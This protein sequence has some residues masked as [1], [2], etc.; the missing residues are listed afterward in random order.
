VD[1]ISLPH[2]FSRGT[3][4]SSADLALNDSLMLCSTYLDC[5]KSDRFGSSC[6]TAHVWRTESAHRSCMESGVYLPKSRN[7]RYHYLKPER[8]VL[9]PL[10]PVLAFGPFP[11]ILRLLCSTTPPKA[12][13][14]SL[15]KLPSNLLLLR[16]LS[17]FIP[18]LFS[19]EYDPIDTF[20]PRNSYQSFITIAK[21]A[22]F[23]K[24]SQL[25]L[26]PTSSR[27]PTVI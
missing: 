3:R 18:L 6:G 22:H 8:I 14:T 13:P 23:R 10:L 7:S 26:F 9:E 21:Q 27:S 24:L 17:L 5:G 4:D 11:S 16:R 2:Q 15:E 25:C 12:P 20:S 19:P 1:G